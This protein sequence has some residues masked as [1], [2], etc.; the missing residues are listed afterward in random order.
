VLLLLLSW[1]LLRCSIKSLL[2][3]TGLVKLQVSCTDEVLVGLHE[4]VLEQLVGQAAGVHGR[5]PRFSVECQ[6]QHLKQLHG[7][8]GT[9]RYYL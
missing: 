3:G 9:Y 6:Q 2:P 7:R 8:K 5:L 1:L 4:A